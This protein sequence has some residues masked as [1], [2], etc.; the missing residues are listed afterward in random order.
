MPSHF[1]NP[2][3]QA[4]QS[5]LDILKWKLGKGL[6]D[7]PW[8]GRATDDP[9]PLQPLSK[10]SIA[11]PPPE[12][13]RITWLGHA[14]FLV[15]GCGLSLLIDPVFSDYCS[16]LPIAS[17]KRLVAPPCSLSD[18]PKIDAVLLSHGHYDHLDLPTLRQLGTGTRLVVADGHA[19]WLGKRGFHQVEEVPWH[20]TVEIIPGVT[21][22][23]TPAQHFTARTP[24]DRNRAHWCGWLIEGG[25]RK[26]WHTGD[27]AW[28]PAFAEIGERYA[29]IDFGMIPIG[30]YNPRAIMESVHVTPE[31][32]VE[33]FILTKCRRAVGMHWGT[34][35]LTDEPMSEPPARLVEA[36]AARGIQ[37][38]EVIPVGGTI[39]I[40]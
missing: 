21:V 5:F 28:C 31:E 25:G 32:A 6:R 27:S 16:P 23:A 24:W 1:T 38:F 3:P 22:T 14:S 10:E 17:L 12:G 26:L 8:H 19:R 15:Q 33:A 37:T 34:F 4:P 40:D 11:F 39:H 2:W 29:P 36:C 35:R 7:A 30:A 9:A 20:E 13:W 18:L